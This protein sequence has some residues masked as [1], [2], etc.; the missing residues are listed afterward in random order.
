M[1]F[2]D[3]H[4]A[5]RCRLQPVLPAA[6]FSRRPVTRVWHGPGGAQANTIP[7]HAC[8]FVIFSRTLLV[9]HNPLRRDT[10][11]P[12]A[13]RPRRYEF[14]LTNGDTHVQES[15][16]LN[17]RHATQIRSGAVARIDVHQG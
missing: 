17:E 12:R 11:G 5:L 14:T 1:F 16:W 4:G 10:F 13:V 9:H 3:E 8:A 6:Y 7:Q 2:V 15:E